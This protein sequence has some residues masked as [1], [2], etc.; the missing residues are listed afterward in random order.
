MY[1][2]FSDG[3]TEEIIDT[4]TRTVSPSEATPGA[5]IEWWFH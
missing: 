2:E 3:S 5:T 4:A 1:G